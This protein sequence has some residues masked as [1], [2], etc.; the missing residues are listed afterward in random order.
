MLHHED[1]GWHAGNREYNERSIGIE[2]EGTIS[3][4]ENYTMAMIESSARLTRWLCETLNIPMDRNHIIGHVEVPGTTHTDPGPYWPWDTFMQLV[5]DGVPGEV[6]PAERL[7]LSS[8][9][10]DAAW[11]HDAQ[12][13]SQTMLDPSSHGL[14]D[15]DP[16]SPVPEFRS[17]GEITGGCRSM[18]LSKVGILPPVFLIFA[19]F[20]L[21]FRK[22]PKAV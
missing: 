21:L 3:D 20:F 19:L 6:I 16:E 11:I 10:R 1:V 17:S 14:D 22:N 2:H 13:T 7:Q 15:L 18:T 12:V 9:F 8:E 4:P 5:E